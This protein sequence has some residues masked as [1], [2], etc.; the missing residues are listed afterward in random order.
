MKGNEMGGAYAG[1]RRGANRWRNVR[2]S[3]L[4]E[5]LTVGGRIIL[6]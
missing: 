5:D 4:S 2:E 6:K 3:Y 1:E